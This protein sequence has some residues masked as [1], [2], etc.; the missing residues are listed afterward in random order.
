[1][2]AK[3]GFVKQE[4]IVNQR[5]FLHDHT[6]YFSNRLGFLPVLWNYLSTHSSLPFLR[7]E[8]FE[9]ERMQ[10][11]HDS[12]VTLLH[13]SFRTT[14]VMLVCCVAVLHGWV[15]LIGTMVRRALSHAHLDAAVSAIDLVSEQFVKAIE[16]TGYSEGAV[17]R[18]W[19]STF[20]LGLL[21]LS[22][23]P[24]RGGSCPALQG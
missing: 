2:L 1:M 18:I 19:V 6:S 12:Q 22:V 9:V 21:L 14:V 20:V 10:G 23:W 17:D 3:Q 4:S 15:V 7:S 24:L 11:I 5:S 13:R 8:D 16:A